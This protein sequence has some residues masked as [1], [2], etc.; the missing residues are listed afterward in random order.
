MPKIIALCGGC[1]K[2]I[3]MEQWRYNAKI[4]TNKTGQ[5]YH[6][7]C[8]GRTSNNSKKPAK[9]KVKCAH[10]GNDTWINPRSATG[11]KRATPYL[12]QP[13]MEAWHKDRHKNR[14][15]CS[16]CGNE[17]LY[18]SGFPGSHNRAACLNHYKDLVSFMHEYLQKG[19]DKIVG[20]LMWGA[21]E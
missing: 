1:H 12:C 4:T 17:A 13:C 3:E 10:C 15:H 14:S 19:E 7:G 8:S 20:S 16:W 9:Q 21:N 6:H 5:V 18:K 11:E 2:P